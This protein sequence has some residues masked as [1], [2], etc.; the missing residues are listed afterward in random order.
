MKIILLSSIILL[1]GCVELR[2]AMATYGA[3]GSDQTLDTAVW[4]ICLASPVG[5]VNRRF[6]T[7]EELAALAVLCK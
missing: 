4:T 6:K 3:E 1:S 5:A 7:E 2:S